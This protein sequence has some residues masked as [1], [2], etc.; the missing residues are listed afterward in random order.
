ARNPLIGVE[1][2]QRSTRP[3]I[4]EARRTGDLR[5]GFRKIELMRNARSPTVEEISAKC[6]NHLRVLEPPARPRDAVRVTMRFD[7]RVIGLEVHAE[8]RVHSLRREPSVEK[9][10]EAAALVLIQKHGA[11]G[12][13]A[14]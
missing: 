11:G 14:G 8:M 12:G 10:R 3:D 6:D 13:A 2:S 4:N 5:A 1:P 9:R 7:R